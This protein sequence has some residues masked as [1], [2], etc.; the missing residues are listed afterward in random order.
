MTFEIIIIEPS[1]SS[2]QH[3]CY[4]NSYAYLISSSLVCDN[5][6]VKARSSSGDMIIMYVG[7]FSSSG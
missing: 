3:Y 1:S 6:Y 4:Y 5:D 7:L 2:D